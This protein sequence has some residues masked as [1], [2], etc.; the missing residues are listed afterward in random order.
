MCE[1]DGPRCSFHWVVQVGF[2]A[3]IGRVQCATA[4]VLFGNCRFGPLAPLRGTSC[5]VILQRVHVRRKL[6]D[7]SEDDGQVDGNAK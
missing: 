1:W 3:E 6:G 5:E 2:D 4:H 7:L